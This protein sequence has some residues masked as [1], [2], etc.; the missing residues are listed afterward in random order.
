[1]PE[2]VWLFGLVPIEEII[3]VPI[4]L[5]AIVSQRDQGRIQLLDDPI[6]ALIVGHRPSVSQCHLLHLSVD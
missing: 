1:M 4:G 2:V 6:H 5:T 3:G